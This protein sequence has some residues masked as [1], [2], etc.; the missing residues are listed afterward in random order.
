MSINTCFLPFRGRR[1]DT[2]YCDYFGAA[3]DSFLY[4]PGRSGHKCGPDL[5]DLSEE[6]D[7]LNFWEEQ[8]FHLLVYRR[9]FW[10]PQSL[11]P[12]LWLVR[13]R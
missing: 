13:S 9:V 8:L 1:F 4:F 3:R 7:L 5:L 2:F 10:F 6:Q 12:H 11:S